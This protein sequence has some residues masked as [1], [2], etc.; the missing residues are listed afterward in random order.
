MDYIEY[1]LSAIGGATVS[2]PV[3]A[4]LASTLI[5]SSLSK[6]LEC[7]KLDLKLANDKELEVIKSSL[8]EDLKEKEITIQ[9]LHER[10][11]NLIQ[12]LYSSLVDLNYLSQMVLGF[13]LSSEPAE[14]RK[15]LETAYRK[16]Q[17]VYGAYL[18]TRIFLTEETC[19]QIEDVLNS[20]Q[21]PLVRYFAISGNYD[22]DELHTLSDVKFSSLK[23]MGEK[24]PP[25]MLLV[26]KEF[27][28]LIGTIKNS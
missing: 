6:E 11:S 3:A 2:I 12:E 20:I 9:W 13:T 18:K 8:N 28:K 24:V 14:Q 10:R 27:R 22:D 4:W 7:Y 23:E 16:T 15:Q 19:V 26:E 1:I 25:A 17:D 21:D 5:K